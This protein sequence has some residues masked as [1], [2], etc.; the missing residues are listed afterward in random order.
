MKYTVLVIAGLLLITGSAFSAATPT[1]APSPSP[2]PIPETLVPYQ[3]RVNVN[4]YATF[5]AQTAGM[6]FT[7]AR[8]RQPLSVPSGWTLYIT[9]INWSCSSAV[10][11]Y[12]SWGT[13]SGLV[14]DSVYFP[15]TG[16]GKSTSLRTAK[17]STS[18]GTAPVLT[19][20]RAATGVVLIDGYLE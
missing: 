7:N 10:N 4:A 19:T 9:D 11:A 1:P 16:Q 20:D 3:T 14:V 15:N 18:A 6:S 13:T 8:T 5:A 17:Y 2:T 12:I